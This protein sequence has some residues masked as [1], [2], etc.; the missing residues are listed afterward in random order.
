MRS[1]L[2]SP[3]ALISAAL[4]YALLLGS[5]ALAAVVVPS[6]VELLPT[7]P[8]LAMLGVLGLVLSPG[9]VIVVVHHASNGKLEQ[10]E[11]RTPSAARGFLPDVPSVSAG[12]HGW[13]VLYGSS[14][15]TT[16]IMLVVQPPELEPETFGAMAL[17]SRLTG[18]H[19]ASAQTAVWI[20]VA[21]TFFELQRRVHDRKSVT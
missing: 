12:A 15:L 7:S 16:V 1:F 17:V 2:P 20:A 13:L 4:L 9:L 18:A 5:G 6:L 8:H 14:L 10:L 21:A 19:A 3:S 11:R